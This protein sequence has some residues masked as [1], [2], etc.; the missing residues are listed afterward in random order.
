MGLPCRA[1][2]RIGWLSSWVAGIGALLLAGHASAY[3][4]RQSDADQLLHDFPDR[5]IPVYLATADGPSI[6]HIGLS[7]TA[8]A[9]ILL[10]VIARHN[11]TVTSPKLY[12][13]GFVEGG[14][15]NYISDEEIDHPF[16]FG[17]PA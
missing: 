17:P 12:F 16:F 5:R 7:A 11:E 2:R 3:C 8:S 4:V 6:E 13:V 10:D 9:R 14:Y 15:A 1:L